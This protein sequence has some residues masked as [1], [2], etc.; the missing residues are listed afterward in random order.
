MKLLK[1]FIPLLT[2]VALFSGALYAA[3]EKEDILSRVD[4]DLLL[5]MS[6][7]AEAHEST[8]TAP[9]RR[10]Y[11]NALDR[12]MSDTESLQGFINELGI[13]ED[14]NVATHARYILSALQEPIQTETKTSSSPSKS[15]S[16]NKNQ[17]S[18]AKANDPFSRMTGQ[19]LSELTGG[20]DST[21]SAAGTWN[22]MSA[23]FSFHMIG[24]AIQTL[25]SLG[26]GLRNGKYSVSPKYRR[27][28]PYLELK[29][30]VEYFNASYEHFDSLI[31]TGV[32][33]SDFEKRLKR[34]TKL[35]AKVQPVYNAYFPGKTFTVSTEAERLTSVYSRFVGY[36]K[37]VEQA[38]KEQDRLSDTT[39]AFGQIRQSSIPDKGLILRDYDTAA[40]HFAEFFAEM[41]SVDWTSNPFSSEG[42]AKND[43]IQL[44]ERAD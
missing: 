44:P 38:R 2:A 30:D 12:F 5:L 14:L 29:R 26:F 19:S 16:K 39:N 31:G 15:T 41:D 20:G 43:A 42:P 13:G 32:W 11:Q 10:Q 3:D 27:I 22:R 9:F 34:M 37:A 23:G 28:L 40:S 7:F 1:S 17:S 18:T 25:S 24:N 4:R 8:V 33:R 6:G 35:A 21:D 36:V